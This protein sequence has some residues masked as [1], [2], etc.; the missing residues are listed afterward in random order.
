ME[1]TQKQ[2]EILLGLLDKFIEV[3]EQNGF[4]YYLNGGSVLGAVRH[5]GFIPW[6]DDI[7]V[8]LFRSDYER[9]QQLS[10]E[11]WGTQYRLASW[12]TVK[13]YRYDFLKLE[14][15][16]TTVIERYDPDYIGCVFLDIFPLDYVPDDANEREQYFVN[17]NRVRT[18]YLRRFFNPDCNCHSLFDVFTQK[19]F[20]AFTNDIAL[21][22]RWEKIAA[23]TG[24]S[25]IVSNSHSWYK[26][27]VPIEY[28]ADGVMLPFEGRMCRV[29]K[30]WDL[31]LKHRFGDYMQLPPEKQRHGHSFDYVN[32]EK[33]ISDKEAKPILKILHQKYA[34]KVSIKREVKL[35]LHKLHLR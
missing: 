32:Y 29:P 10:S 23:S 3:C 17:L 5:K 16:H 2:K 33:H 8:Y 20:R 13:N 18:S 1:I 9:I 26:R 27:P 25:T 11:V 4:V 22:E 15:I 24:H 6:D 34:Y 35:F 14:N 7:D 31:Y 30:E 28:F 19:C 21:F 12:R